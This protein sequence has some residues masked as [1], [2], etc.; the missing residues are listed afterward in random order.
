MMFVLVL[1]DVFSGSMLVMFFSLRW[2]ICWFN[3]VRF[4]GFN[5]V[6]S[7]PHGWWTLWNV[8]HDRWEDW[9]PGIEIQNSP[10]N[11][12]K[13][14]TVAVSYVIHAWYFSQWNIYPK[15][16]WSFAFPKLHRGAHVAAGCETVAERACGFDHVGRNAANKK[17]L[18][19]DDAWGYLSG[20][21][22]GCDHTSYPSHKLERHEGFHL[23][24]G[25]ASNY[26]ILFP[27]GE[28]PAKKVIPILLWFPTYPTR[29]RSLSR[30]HR[31]QKGQTRHPF[32]KW[33]I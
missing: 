19:G 6:E 32:W 20:Q 5:I 10:Q 2:C 12:E 30:F 28:L 23:L 4:I 31:N 8:I 24:S 18:P 21:Y 29:K 16:T 33:W 9:Y 26:G 22:V 27:R 1:C 17:W 13:P 15:Q 11:L 7:F 25:Y 14:P 3:M